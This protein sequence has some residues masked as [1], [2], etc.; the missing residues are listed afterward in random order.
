MLYLKDKLIADLQDSTKMFALTSAERHLTQSELE[1]LGRGIRVYG[2]GQ[3][4]CVFASDAD[5]PPGELEFRAPGVRV[6]YLDSAGEAR[7]GRTPAWLA[8]CRQVLNAC[9]SKPERSSFGFRLRSSVV[10]RMWW[11]EPGH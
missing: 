6:G 11:F 3:L 7:E 4:P 1:D 9:H 8:L 5:H 10:V 2:P